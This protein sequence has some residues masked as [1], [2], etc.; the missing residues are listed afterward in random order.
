MRVGA[1]GESLADI[2][3]GNRIQRFGDRRE[4]IA[5]HFR[6][7]PQRDVVGRRRGRQQQPALFALEYA[8]AELWK[9]WGIKPSAVMGHSLGEYVAACL[10]GVFSLEEALALV[11]HRARLL[12]GLLPGVM[13]SVPLPEHEVKELIEGRLSLAAVNG[14]SQCVVSGAVAV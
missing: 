14:P 13:L 3:M 12:M 1:R 10:A 9:S 4:L 2:R 8:L 6:L 11:M 7:A 5:S